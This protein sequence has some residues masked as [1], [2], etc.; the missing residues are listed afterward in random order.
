M[1]YLILSDIH[2]NLE[3]LDAVLSTASGLYDRI[4]CCG[5]LVGYGPDPNAIVE[6]AR[7]NLDAVIRGNHDKGCCGLDDLSWFNPVARAA[8]LWT[9]MQLT[10]GNSEYLH[11]LPAGPLDLDGFQLVHGSPLDEDEYLISPMDARNV[12][13]YMEADLIFFGHTHV[14]CAWAHVEGRYEAIARMRREDPDLSM[15][16]MPDGAY[17]INPGSVGQPRDNDPRA[18]YAIFDS[19]TRD[20]L[21]RRCYYDSATTAGK[22]YDAGLPDILATRLQAGR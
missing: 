4:V 22:I 18:G 16:L 19:E 2:S 1:R 10:P 11:A 21:Q 9:S 13:P 6:W 20:L 17:L 8:C 3:A 7:A 12:F 5:D 15:K 14:Q